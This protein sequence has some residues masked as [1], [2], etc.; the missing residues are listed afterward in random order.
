MK[1]GGEQVGTHKHL[2]PTYSKK[3]Q[4]YNKSHT[5]IR[6]QAQAHMTSQPNIREQDELTQAHTRQT[7]P[8]VRADQLKLDTITSQPS[9]EVDL[10]WLTQIG[11]PGLNYSQEQLDYP[12]SRRVF[13]YKKCGTPTSLMDI[14]TITHLHPLDHN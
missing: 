14:H 1:E 5:P 10:N 13:V 6:F 9:Q 4:A 11:H 2:G 8:Q 12:S 3:A 7:K